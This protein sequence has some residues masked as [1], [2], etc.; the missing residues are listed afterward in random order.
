MLNHE[1][2]ENFNIVEKLSEFENKLKDETISQIQKDN[3]TAIYSKLSDFR[4]IA[5]HKSIA[6][7]QR[8][9]YNNM[10]NNSDILKDAIIIEVL[11]YSIY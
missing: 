6:Q 10:I 3:F 2:N 1:L 4:E 9:A 11:F 5:Y 7:R 8:T